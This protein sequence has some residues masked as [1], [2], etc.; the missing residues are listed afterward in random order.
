MNGPP[1]FADG[2]YADDEKPRR[3]PVW[4]PGK[5]SEKPKV[6]PTSAV[7]RFMRQMFMLEKG[8]YAPEGQRPSTCAP[9]T[10]RLKARNRG[11]MN[12]ATA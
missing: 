1:V 11:Q 8:Y 12:G 5:K 9:A 4:R 2:V 7:L 3:P 10:R 6:R